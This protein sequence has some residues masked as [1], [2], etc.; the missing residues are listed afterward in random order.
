MKA[1]A[2]SRLRRLPQSSEF[3]GIDSSSVM[4][5]KC[6]ADELLDLMPAVSADIK[7]RGRW[8]FCQVHHQTF[9]QVIQFWYGR[10]V[11][12]TMQIT[13]R[14]TPGIGAHWPTAAPDP[15]GTQFQRLALN[16]HP[17]IMA[18]PGDPG[19]RAIAVS[20]AFMVPANSAIQRSDHDSE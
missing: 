11:D 10:S 20:C 12:W 16:P 7:R 5:L 17:V 13:K 6:L 9:P 18:Q 8:L 2:I 1:V 15:A 19:S 14:R 4:G 3:T